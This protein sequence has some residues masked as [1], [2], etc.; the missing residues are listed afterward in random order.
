MFLPRT[1]GS[2]ARRC[3]RW[4]P[5]VQEDAASD[6]LIV[7]DA[8]V[9]AFG[10]VLADDAGELLRARVLPL[11]GRTRARG[12]ALERRKMLDVVD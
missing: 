3:A 1:G 9:G 6:E 10:H 2:S 5:E 4:Q 8:S 12:V 11:L 7:D